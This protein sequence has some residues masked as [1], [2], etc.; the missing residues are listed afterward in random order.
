MT[1]DLKTLLWIL[2][3]KGAAPASRIRAKA[4]ERLAVAG[5]L[6]ESEGLCRLTDA[7]LRYAQA[8]RSSA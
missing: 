1:K 5:F 3:R 8:S 7:G 2:D 6:T 4:R